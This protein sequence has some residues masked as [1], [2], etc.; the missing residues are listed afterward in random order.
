[1]AQQTHALVLASVS[2]RRREILGQ[3]G[4]QFRVVPSRVEEQ[5]IP[6]EAP[7]DFALRM[8]LAKADEVA[9]RLGAAQEKTSVLGADTVVVINGDVL[10]KPRDQQDAGRML[11][12]LSGTA[13]QVITAV[14]L[15]QADRGYRD[16]VVVT[17]TVWFRELDE[18]TVAG[19][20]ASGEGLDKAGSYAIQ[21]LGAGVVARIDGSY[22]NVVGLPATH[23]L[24]LLQ[25]AGLLG[26]WP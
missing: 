16:H 9:G 25:R 2:P 26:Q 24:V 12:Q 19:Y 14:A 17:T 6:E 23:T 4:L 11:R 21:G 20:A 15:R 3:L 8:A 22:S 7:A 10:G 5:Q 18:A 1:M 13:H